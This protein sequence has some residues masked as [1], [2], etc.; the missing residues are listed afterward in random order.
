MEKYIEI[1]K[2]YLVNSSKHLTNGICLTIR[3][4]ELDNSNN[5]EKLI[6]E[7]L[8]TVCYD[9]SLVRKY[10]DEYGNEYLL[11]FNGQKRAD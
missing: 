3:K 5:P 6:K 10:I 2:K 8:H 1:A 7:K 4:K 11:F 9:F